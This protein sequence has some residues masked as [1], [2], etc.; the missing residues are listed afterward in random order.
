MMKRVRSMNGWQRLWSLV[1]GLGLLYALGWGMVE[2][3]HGGGERVQA[4]VVAAYENPLCRAIV[5]MPPVSKLNP[6]PD[7]EGPCWELY[8]YK[9][10]YE[11]AAPTSN[12]YVQD[13]NTRRREWLLG[14]I[15]IALAAWF[16]AS[17]LLYGAGWLIAWVRRGFNQSAQSK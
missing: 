2:G 12:G 17:G 16:I 13:I 6:E 10:I 5:D 3:Q 9:S 7:G 1:A 15:G 4:E 14:T 11:T 8:L